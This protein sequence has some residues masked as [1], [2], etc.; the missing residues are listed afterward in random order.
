MSKVIEIKPLTRVEG[1]G[2]V[3]VRMEGGRVQDVQLAL[4][5]SPR[6]F[7]ALLVGK[8]YDELPEIICRICSICSSVHRVVSL[9]A[10]EKAFGVQ[11]SLQTALYRELIV[12]GGHIESHAL[13]L[14]CLALPDYLDVPGFA[15]LAEKAPEEFRMGLAIKAAG[16]MVQ[17]MV[18]G[19]LIHPVNLIP[20]GMGKPVAREGLERLK[21]ALESALPHA[22]KTFE[23]FSTFPP[24]GA[25]PGLAPP[26]PMAVRSGNGSALFGNELETGE[27]AV[28]PVDAYQ[29]FIRE[30]A[31]EHSNAKQ[32]LVDG[33]P[34]AVG[35]L[36]RLKLGMHLS[37]AA[38]KALSAVADGIA[39][40]GMHANNLAQAVELVHGVERSIELINAILEGDF[41]REEAVRPTIRKGG[42]IAAIEAPRGALIHSYT[43]DERG[44][45]IAADIVTPTA[46][47]QAAMERDLFALARAKECEGEEAMAHALEILVRA[48]D[49]C[50]SCA[51]HLIKV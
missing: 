39:G 12:N 20:G 17:E 25:V 44:C 14:F 23:L 1:H 18:G 4:N 40:A 19:R 22:V 41:V 24:L 34:V 8:R 27:M 7:E 10:L 31:V 48:Y 11:V 46:M 37:P 42:G 33:V 51:V 47:N 49:P 5:E 6:L 26:I 2:K 50:I 30:E 16:N 36:S 15:G 28:I 13:H 21:G 9:L 45:C 38:R 3:M 32:S 43:F 29:R 35:A